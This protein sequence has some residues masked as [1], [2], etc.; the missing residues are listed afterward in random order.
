MLSD[1]KSLHGEPGQGGGPPGGGPPGG[2]PPGGLDDS[3]DPMWVPGDIIYNGKKWYRSG[4][5]FKG[6]S[7]LVSTWSRGLLKLA[8]KLDFDEF[9]DEYP[10]ID[11]Q[12]FYGF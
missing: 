3:E 4:V 9:E 8:F 1:M 11:N 12:R 2:G 7:S 5:R 6:N 10:Q